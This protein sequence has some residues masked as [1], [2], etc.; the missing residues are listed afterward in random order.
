[1]AGNVQAF[2]QAISLVKRE[3]AFGTQVADA[4]LT[5]WI[6]MDEFAPS[7]IEKEFRTNSNRINGVRGKTQRQLKS[8]AGMI[9][10]KTD[11]SVELVTSLLA[12]GSG[13]NIASSGSADPW[14]HTIKDPTLCTTYPHS[15]SLVEGIVCA[16]LTSGY[17][18]YKGICVDQ[19]TLEGSGRD[20]VKLS[21]NLKHDGSETT[22]SSFSFPASLSVLT[23]LLNSHLAFKLYPNGGGVIDITDKVLSWK[24]T[25]NYGVVPTKTSNT[26]IYVP[27]Y[28]YSKGNP[29][30]A[31]EFVVSEDKSGTIYGY[32]DAETLL[33]LQLSLTVS[34]SR[35]I[36]VLMD[37]VYIMADE[38]SDDLE[39]TLN[40]KVDPLDILADSGPDVWTCKTA[41]PLY[42]VASP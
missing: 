14:T 26:G 29:N 37:S 23:Y 30:I 31:V 17:K 33:T 36:S 1:M 40:C 27:R 24:I 22:K 4:D 34:A 28:K 41:S 11:A 2:R 42:L 6:E 5:T 7:K 38:E 13:G 10:R 25:K 39:P 3:A 8:R 18:L 15:T 12:L 35:S 20:E 9:S 32:S 16:G 21:Y 19:I